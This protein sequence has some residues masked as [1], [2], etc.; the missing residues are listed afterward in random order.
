METELKPCPFCGA[1]AEIAEFGCYSVYCSRQC[2]EQP[3]AYPDRKK[4]TEAW[5]RRVG[6]ADEIDFD[7]E[8]EVE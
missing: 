7:Y 6:Q 8:A 2:C 4:A 3:I 5:N 1:K